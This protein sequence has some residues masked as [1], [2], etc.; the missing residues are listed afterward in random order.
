MSEAVG[1]DLGSSLG[2]HVKVAEGHLAETAVTGDE[3]VCIGA[4]LAKLIWSLFRVRFRFVWQSVF[5]EHD[6]GRGLSDGREV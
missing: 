2:V 5:Q 4:G 1:H 3:A 6:S